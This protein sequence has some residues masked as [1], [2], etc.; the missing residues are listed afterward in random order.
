MFNVC[1]NELI[2]FTVVSFK[3]A[4]MSL[5]EYSCYKSKHTYTQHQLMALLCLMKRLRLDYR[6][7]TSIIQLMPEICLILGLKEIPHHIMLQK[8]FKRTKS[9][10]IDEI[11]D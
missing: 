5:S 2:K 4:E 10:I 7:F 1:D 6:L 8:L 9:Q 3:L 11:I